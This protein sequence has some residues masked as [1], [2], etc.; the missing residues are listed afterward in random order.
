RPLRR[1]VCTDYVKAM[2]GAMRR[3]GISL[4][5]RQL[6]CAP[7]S[8][9]EGRSYLGAMAAA[10]NF[11]WANRQGIANAVRTAVSRTL[12]QNVADGTRQVYDVAHN[13]AHAEEY[14]RRALVLH[15]HAPA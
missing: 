6:A 1:Q 7:A 5:D 11:A 2:D 4:P 13:G 15:P 10:A 8:S 3:Y 12:G 14:H 9:P